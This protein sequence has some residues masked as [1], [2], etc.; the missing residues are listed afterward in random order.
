MTA[1][2]CSD[3]V[4][5]FYRSFRSA[6]GCHLTGCPGPGRC[7]VLGRPFSC[8]TWLFPGSP[9][10]A[11]D[12]FLAAYGCGRDVSCL[13]LPWCITS[14]LVWTA[15]P[16]IFRLLPPQQSTF[17]YRYHSRFA[18]GLFSSAR[19]SPSTACRIFSSSSSVMMWLLKRALWVGTRSL[20]DGSL[21]G[22]MEKLSAY[23]SSR[24]Q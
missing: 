3:A 4:I 23:I 8:R 14:A 15:A 19:I 9:A 10:P 22:S 1:S 11:A 13:A 20:G 17:P 21:A 18:A 7:P 12:R 16:L 2:V 6:A 24:R 5:C